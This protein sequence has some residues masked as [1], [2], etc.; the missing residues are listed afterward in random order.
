VSPT[1]ETPPE[2]RVLVADDSAVMR[3]ALSRI[4]DSGHNMRVCGTARNGLEA[5]EKTR[6]LKPDVVTLDIRMPVM[7]GLEALKRIMSECPRPVIM[8][9]CLTQE[10]AEATIEALS[11]GAFDYI[12]KEEIQDDDQLRQLRATLLEKV[13][14]AA[15]S[16]LILGSRC[17][18]PA[19]VQVPARALT[20]VVPK[21]AVLGTST[22][23]PRALQEIIPDLPADFPMPVLVVQ[24]MPRGFTTPLAKRLNS[25]SKIEVREATQGE[26]ILPG[27][28]YIAPAGRHTTVFTY[29]SN[30]NIC[31]SD[32]PNDTTHK[33]SVDVT[34]SSAAEAYG[35][36][37]LGVI[38]TGMGSD[39]L[40]G[41]RAIHEAGGITVG[42]DEASCAVYGMPRSCAENGVLQRVVSLDEVALLM[43]EVARYRDR[44]AVTVSP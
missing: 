31:L 14:A 24:H 11:A 13:E 3:T 34:M 35:A 38:L 6:L 5:L 8:V 21:I 30:A 37:V 39:G 18:T 22:G 16:S 27:V 25:I 41:M 15:Q 29:G 7:D 17:P 44:P 2:I 33:P 12:P 23:G 1:A 40:K 36:A 4:L 20:H 32:Y 9:S 19:R 43:I 42:Q 26:V 10:G 28:V